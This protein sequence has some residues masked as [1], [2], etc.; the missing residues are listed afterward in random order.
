MIN[1][2]NLP[3]GFF[4]L[5]DSKLLAS[6]VSQV[7]DFGIIVEL[8]SFLGRTAVIIGRHAKSNVRIFCIDSFPEKFKCQVHF[9]DWYENQYPQLGQEFD[10]YNEFR[11][12]TQEFTNITVIKGKSPNEIKFTNEPIDMFFLDAAHKNP[13]CLENLN[14]FCPLVKSNG[15]ICGHDFL[16]KFPDVQQNVYML[17]KLYNKKATVSSHGSFWM[18]RKP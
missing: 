7:P 14:F 13:N 16:D 17:E 8:G 18:I 5:H 3:I 11:K 1:L 2:D 10:V 15:I 9:D 4:N 12:N 6:L